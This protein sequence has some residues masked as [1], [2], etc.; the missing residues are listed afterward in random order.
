[1]AVKCEQS[2]PQINVQLNSLS[3]M[4]TSHQMQKIKEDI[5]KFGINQIN[6]KGDQKES[7]AN[8]DGFQL[9]WFLSLKILNG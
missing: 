1:M 2:P 5:L 7:Y 4:F 8:V 9:K 6:L 3:S